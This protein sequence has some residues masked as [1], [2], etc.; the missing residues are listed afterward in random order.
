M[1]WAR[2]M[3]QKPKVHLFTTDKSA[4]KLLRLVFPVA[5]IVCVVVPENRVG[6]K[7]VSELINEA[8]VPIVFHSKENPEKFLEGAPQAT[9]AISFLY[10]QIIC[11]QALS[12]YHDGAL[13]FHGGRIPEYRGANV[14]NWALAS[15]EKM[16][17]ATWHEMKEQLDSG[18]I[19]AEAPIKV[20]QNDTAETCREKLISAALRLFLPAW[21]RYVFDKKPIRTPNL[22]EGR[23]WPSRKEEDGEIMNFLSKSDIQNI[24]LAQSSDRFPPAY[25][26]HNGRKY[27]ILGVVEN[28][29]QGHI[30]YEASDGSLLW[31]KAQLK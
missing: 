30:P 7:K 12:V 29:V 11:E 14:L 25:R 8:N 6:S 2:Y 26:V 17:W 24:L 16:L 19:F 5:E 3:V 31:L 28:P 18:A 9:F 10:S 23:L 15:G 20:E 13:N 1:R 27:E 22:Q 21:S 4:L